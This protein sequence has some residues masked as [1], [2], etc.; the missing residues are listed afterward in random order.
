M[1]AKWRRVLA[2]S[3]LRRKQ[4]F[5]VWHYLSLSSAVSRAQTALGPVRAIT[6]CWQDRADRPVQQL[7]WGRRERLRLRSAARS[8]PSAG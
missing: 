2:L 6:A 8:G 4:T 3:I 1:R 7:P 5:M